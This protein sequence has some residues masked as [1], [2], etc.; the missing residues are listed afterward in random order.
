MGKY[1]LLQFPSG[2]GPSFS[3]SLLNK[4]FEFSGIK[5]LQVKCNSWVCVT[6]AIFGT[7]PRFRAAGVLNYVLLRG[8]DCVML[9][10]FQ[11]WRVAGEANNVFLTAQEVGVLP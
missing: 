2:A 5:I 11:D 6:N 10:F 7:L 3:L 8:M 1:F 4:M 9:R